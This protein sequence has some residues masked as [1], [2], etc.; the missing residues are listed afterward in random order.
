M[1]DSHDLNLG[2][3]LTAEEEA[4]FRRDSKRAAILAGAPPA[5]SMP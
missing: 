1:T 2:R 3:P 5:L 4:H